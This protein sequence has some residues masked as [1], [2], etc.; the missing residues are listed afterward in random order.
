MAD[1]IL[2]LNSLNINL[3][4]SELNFFTR[5]HQSLISGNIVAHKVSN[6]HKITEG[7]LEV[8]YVFIRIQ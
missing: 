4:I 7:G 8:C 6:F 1:T 3:Q 2:K 5:K